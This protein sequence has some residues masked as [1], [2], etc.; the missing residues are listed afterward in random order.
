[1]RTLL[2]TGPGGAGTSTLAAAAAVRSARPAGAR[3]CCRG[4]RPRCRAWTTWPGSPS[5][6]SIRRRRSSGSGGA[7]REPSAP[8]VPHLTLPP[9]SSV[10]PLPGTAEIALFAEL[11]RA[12]ADLVVLDAGPLEAMGALVA[13]PAGLRWWLDQAMPPGMRTLGAVRTAAVAAGAAK[14]GPVDVALK[15]VP[16]V[17][18]LLARNPLAGPTT[19]CLVTEP[20]RTA[21]PALRAAVTHARAARPDRRRRPRPGAAARRRGRVG[22]AAVGR[23][24]RRPVGAGRRGTGPPGARARRP[25]GATSTSWPPCWTAPPS[26]AEPPAPPRR[27]SGTRAAGS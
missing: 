21:V 24:G 9:E 7:P 10:V 2:L 15:L 20:R 22:A 18:R 1:M 4:S 17:E 5:S 8:S 25:A 16:V 19:V 3:S 12:D 14:R 11:A 13:L 26:E 6:G 23:A 27:P